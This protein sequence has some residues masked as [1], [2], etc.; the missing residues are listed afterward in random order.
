MRHVHAL[1]IYLTC[2]H[3]SAA[4]R[5]RTHRHSISAAVAKRRAAVTAPRWSTAHTV[6]AAMLRLA[7]QMAI[8]LPKRV[9]RIYTNGVFSLHHYHPTFCV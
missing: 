1:L 9:V 3:P 4:L 8:L 5:E 2:G 6:C 7:A